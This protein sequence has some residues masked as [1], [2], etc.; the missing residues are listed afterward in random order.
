M[1]SLE[2]RAGLG[3]QMGYVQMWA[4]PL[5]TMTLCYPL[6]LPEKVF[7]WHRRVAER[8]NCP[9]GAG[10]HHQ[11]AAHP[12]QATVQVVLFLPLQ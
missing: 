11:Q 8:C 2:S 1:G 3:W 7:Q 4:V 5:D 10:C 6:S 12:G 9:L